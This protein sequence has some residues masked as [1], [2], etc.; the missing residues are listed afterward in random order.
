MLIAETREQNAAV[1]IDGTGAAAVGRPFDVNTVPSY[2]GTSSASNYEPYYTWGDSSDSID[3]L[4]GPSSMHPGL[5]AHLLADG[6][7]RFIADTIDAKIYD[8]L[9]TRAPAAK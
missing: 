1:W 2:A 9:I 8:A 5:V 3:C 4:Y 7:A 6:S